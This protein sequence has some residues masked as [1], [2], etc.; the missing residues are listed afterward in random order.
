MSKLVRRHHHLVIVLVQA[1]LLVDIGE[2]IVLLLE[3]MRE[4]HELVFLL[5]VDGYRAEALADAL[6]FPVADLRL[7]LGELLQDPE[8]VLGL[9]LELGLN[10]D[11]DKRDEEATGAMGQH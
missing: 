11:G 2:V 10:G 5:L 7:G 3:A 1:R 4:G 6:L 8:W 9:R